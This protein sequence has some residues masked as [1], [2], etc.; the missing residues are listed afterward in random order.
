MTAFE[1]A[2]RWVKSHPWCVAFLFVIIAGYTVGKDMAERDNSRDAYMQAE[3][4]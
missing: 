1:S 3:G 4:A 2:R